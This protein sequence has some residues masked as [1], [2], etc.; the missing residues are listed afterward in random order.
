MSTPLAKAFC[1]FRAATGCPSIAVRKSRKLGESGDGTDILVSDP[2]QT[3]S[4][5][6]KAT[7][8]VTS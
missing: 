4:S 7:V 3:M 5:I 1:S 6:G 2:S 8:V